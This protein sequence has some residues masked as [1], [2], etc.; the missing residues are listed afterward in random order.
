MELL[1]IVGEIGFADLS[2]PGMTSMLPSL[3][4][5]PLHFICEFLRNFYV[6]TTSIPCVPAEL[7][8]VTEGFKKEFDSD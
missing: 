4:E 3:F 6:Q 2:G 5:A 1:E 8:L 7:L